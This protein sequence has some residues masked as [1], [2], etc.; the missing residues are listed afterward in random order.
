M[1]HGYGKRTQKK[2]KYKCISLDTTTKKFTVDKIYKADSFGCLKSDDGHRCWISPI[3]PL[4]FIGEEKLAARRD[5]LI[6]VKPLFAHF[7]CVSD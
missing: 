7:E 2:M 4:Y 3:T 1:K 6:N 5:G